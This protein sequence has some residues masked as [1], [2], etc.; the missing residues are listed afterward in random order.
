MITLELTGGL[1]N[2]LFEYAACYALA[3]QKKTRLS[4]YSQAIDDK[5]RPY[6]LNHFNITY[7]KISEYSV[8]S[9][10]LNPL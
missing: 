4:I 2:Q 6:V 1:G 5:T 3:Q 8:T 7:D 10:P 9:E